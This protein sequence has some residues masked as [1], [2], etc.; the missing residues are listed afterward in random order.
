MPQYIVN[1]NL[2]TGDGAFKK[3]DVY[4][5][6]ETESLL[7]KGYLDAVPGTDD[8]CL[9]GEEK[10]VSSPGNDQDGELIGG[11]DLPPDAPK[12]KKAKKK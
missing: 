2:T 5:G 6:D 12:A 11:P 1:R 8:L 9:P 3:G 10:G 4:E 7:S